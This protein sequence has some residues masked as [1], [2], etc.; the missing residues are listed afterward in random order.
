MAPM[1]LAPHGTKPSVTYWSV[2]R[3]GSKTGRD[4]GGP[5]PLQRCSRP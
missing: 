1:V 4:G 2:I 5:S 3:A